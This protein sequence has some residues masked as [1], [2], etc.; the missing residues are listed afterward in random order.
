VDAL[1]LY[2]IVL[3]P[4]SSTKNS[5]SKETI[6]SRQFTGIDFIDEEDSDTFNADLSTIPT[7]SLN[8]K[9]QGPGRKESRSSIIE[10]GYKY[11]MAATAVPDEQLPGNNPEMTKPFLQGRQVVLYLQDESLKLLPLSYQRA[12]NHGGAVLQLHS[13]LFSQV[14]LFQFFFFFNG[15]WCILFF[16]LNTRIFVL[17]KFI[18]H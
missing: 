10:R 17:H 12:A 4:A 9:R 7:F 5:A 11:A 6:D 13:V 3:L 1:K 2:Q 15:F 14:K 8:V 18:G 16:N